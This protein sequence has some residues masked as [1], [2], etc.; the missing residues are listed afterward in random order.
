MIPVEYAAG[1]TAF[2]SHHKSEGTPY[3]YT[4]KVAYVEKH[5][6]HKQYL[7]INDTVKIQNSDN[8]NKCSP[9]Y[10]H[11][12]CRGGGGGDVFFQRLSVYFFTYG[13]EAVGK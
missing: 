11:H 1:G 4:Y 12:I 10:H 2:C 7:F 8:G 6:Y 9:E 3:E 13:L 5:R